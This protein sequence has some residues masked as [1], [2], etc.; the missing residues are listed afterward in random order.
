MK[1]GW[2]F[3]VKN[4]LLQRSSL[5]T[6]SAWVLPKQGVTIQDKLEDKVCYDFQI[7][8]NL[9]AINKE[10]WNDF[11]RQ[12][13]LLQFFKLVGDEETSIEKQVN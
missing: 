13:N 2:S 4:Q 8:P 11:W 1:Q 7:V 12:Y 9:S 5:V 3:F 10:D 6:G